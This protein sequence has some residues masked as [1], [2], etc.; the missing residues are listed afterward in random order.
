MYMSLTFLTGNRTETAED[1]DDG[2]VFCTLLK[3]AGLQLKASTHSNE[4]CE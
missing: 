2:S 1:Y 3:K 4:L